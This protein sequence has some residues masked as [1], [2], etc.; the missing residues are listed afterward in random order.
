MGN[1]FRKFLYFLIAIFALLHLVKICIFCHLPHTLISFLYIGLWAVLGICFFKKYEDEKELTSIENL[2]KQI[3]QIADKYP[4]VKE[5][6]DTMTDIIYDNLPSD[7][8]SS[9]LIT[10]DLNDYYL[11]DFYCNLKKLAKSNKLKLNELTNFQKSA[12]LI[13][14]LSTSKSWIFQSYDIKDIDD[15]QKI[16]SLNIEFAI[17]SGLLLCGFTI[18]EINNMPAYINYI[19]I[20]ICESIYYNS[21][22]NPMLFSI[23]ADFLETFS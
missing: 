19:K 8:K 14:S 10:I 5:T 17:K 20:L 9:M 4:N 16:T 12:C 13:V 6:V 22:W 3:Q 11:S 1:K 23:I 21:L 18:D 15:N 2:K 7:I